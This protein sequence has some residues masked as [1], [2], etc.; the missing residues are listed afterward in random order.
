MKQETKRTKHVFSPD[1]KADLNVKFRQAWKQV[2]VI[3][4]EFDSV[5]SSYKART[6]EAEAVAAN[7]DALLDAG[8]QLQETECVVVYRPDKREKDYYAA[9][10]L[11]DGAVP[12]DAVPLLT[13]KMDDADMQA[14]LFEAEA[15]FELKDTIALFQPTDKDAGV[16]VVGRFKDRWYGALRAKV[17]TKEIKERLDGEAKGFKKRADCVS[18]SG[19]RFL[20]FVKAN[21]GKDASNGFAAF[22][23]SMNQAHKERE[24]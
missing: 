14:E 6:A 10:S 3:E 22:I 13:E 12:K 23:D 7:L 11:V 1:E 9:A 24:E 17:G 21:I 8:F 15:A 5:K 20:E 19:K 4:A 16:L 18:A 2:T